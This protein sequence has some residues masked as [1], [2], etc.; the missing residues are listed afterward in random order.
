MNFK[1]ICKALVGAICIFM[2]A[3]FA[4]GCGCSNGT[5]YRHEKAT[6]PETTAQQ[7]QPTESTGSASEAEI[8]YFDL[9]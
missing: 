5:Q 9:E 1:N 8:D 7:T 2:I 4:G 3:L 6:E